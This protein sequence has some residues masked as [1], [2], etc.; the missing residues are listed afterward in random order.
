MRFRSEN[1]IRTLTDW[2]RTFTY[3][4]V[5]HQVASYRG[6]SQYVRFVKAHESCWKSDQ[7]VRDLGIHGYPMRML[8]T[9]AI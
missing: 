3:Q 5:V 2:F 6:T 7:V 8:T 1:T 9:G 4:G